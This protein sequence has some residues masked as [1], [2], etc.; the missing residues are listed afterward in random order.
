MSTITDLIE[1]IKT[2]YQ[3]TN[4][5]KPL[6]E[7]ITRLNKQ[8]SDIGNE[9]K[10]KEAIMKQKDEEIEQKNKEIKQKEEELISIKNR[11]PVP[12][13]VP[14]SLS[15]VKEELK[16]ITETKPLEEIK[17][18]DDEIIKLKAEVERLKTIERD[19]PPQTPQEL[20]INTSNFNELLKGFNSIEPP[21][22]IHYTPAFLNFVEQFKI[23]K[24]FGSKLINNLKKAY[25]LFNKSI[26]GETQMDIQILQQSLKPSMAEIKQ[27]VV[28]PKPSMTEIKQPMAEPKPSIIEVKPT[29]KK[30][31]I[32]DE[33][34]TLISNNKSRID[35]LI[36]DNIKLK[37]DV[38]AVD[39]QNMKTKLKEV[40]DNH[41]T[42]IQKIHDIR[43]SSQSGGNPPEESREYNDLIKR[44]FI[45]STA[46]EYLRQLQ[47]METKDL[48]NIS[49]ENAKQYKLK[50][51]EIIKDINLSF[52]TADGIEESPI[53]IDYMNSIDNLKREFGIGITKGGFLK[54]KSKKNRKQN[55]SIT[56]KLSHKV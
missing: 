23:N 8:I 41:S 1:Y 44:E 27:P 17:L 15:E 19:G 10:Q 28:E 55:S 2:N 42:I 40:M 5:G 36:S 33:I 4:E 13:P 49:I 32:T 30:I 7:E 20:K 12:L 3:T 14:N 50:I 39:S 48:K 38:N 16:K 25:A 11:Q 51:N 9:L 34:K 6:M 56:R 24:I 46:D 26:E 54:I 18:K 47:K 35:E 22:D 21:S 29:S 37:E 52:I 43:V 31:N 45:A 53:I